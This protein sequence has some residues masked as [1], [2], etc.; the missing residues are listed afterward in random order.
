MAK[1]RITIDPERCKGCE[2]CTTVCVQ[3]IIHLGDQF[4]R[5]GYRAA[6]V[7][8]PEGKCTGCALCALSCPDT[9]ITVYRQERLREPRLEKMAV[10][11]A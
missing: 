3:Q 4:N 7:V 8:D 6:V 5:R 9:A 10:V 2:I 11:L 1:G